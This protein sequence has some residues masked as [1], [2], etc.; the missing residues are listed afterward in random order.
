MRDGERIQT[1]Y[2]DE[3][4]QS[5]VVLD[6]TLLPGEIRYRRLRDAASVADA[7]GR[8]CVRG[9]PA[10]GVAAALGLY[11]S[12]WTFRNEDDFAAR[13]QEATAT[14]EAARPTAVNLSWAVARMRRA[15]Q[16]L[17]GA[18]ACLD[19]LKA[20]AKRMYEEDRETN[21]RIG[22]FGA[23]LLGDGFGVAT[24]CNAGRLATVDFGTALAPLYEAKEQGKRLRVYVDETR[25][26]LQGAR[27]TAF[28][29]LAS[30][31]DVTLQCD[32]MAASAMQQGLV[33][34]VLVGADRIAANGDTANKIGT[35]PLAICARHFGVP[36]Y[37]CA[38]FSTIDQ[39][40]ADGSHIPVEERDGSEITD[41]WYAKPMAPKGVKT[42]NP[43]FDVTPAG[44]ISALV[45]ERGVLYP[46]FDL[47][48]RG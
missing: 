35:L 15:V 16:G 13:L 47:R 23:A 42:R 2:L 7:I 45:T 43:A 5:L 18:Q 22:R 33:Q 31:L 3:E 24:H 32:G 21:R 36:F 34:A 19:A 30:G 17:S 48:T 38:P 28:E 39:A 6:Q 1:L 46:P 44:L 4:D 9:A 26:L 14:I 12:A 8:L 27:L 40:C 25:P 10:I 20:E 11:A 41:L 37:V 29:L